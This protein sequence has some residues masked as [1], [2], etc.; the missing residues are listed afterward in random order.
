LSQCSPSTIYVMPWPIY[1]L[2]FWGSKIIEQSKIIWATSGKIH[3]NKCSNLKPWLVRPFQG[4]VFRGWI[5]SSS[6]VPALALIGVAIENLLLQLDADRWGHLP[7][8]HTTPPPPYPS[9][10]SQCC[11]HPTPPHPWAP[12]VVPPPPIP[13]MDKATEAM[14]RVQMCHRSQRST[15]TPVAPL[16]SE[17]RSFIH[18]CLFLQL[19]MNHADI[20]I[21]MFKKGIWR[22]AYCAEYV[23]PCATVHKSSCC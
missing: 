16:I 5:G 6:G 19:T 8:T 7:V 4:T 11:H 2:I 23:L 9:L 3:K 18:P 20:S 22:S 14:A 17:F 1:L 21:I 15:A 13:T 10:S 12:L